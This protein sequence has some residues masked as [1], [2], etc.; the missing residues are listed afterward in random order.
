MAEKTNIAWCEATVNFWHGCKKVSEGCKYCYMYRDKERWKQDGSVVK[1]SKKSTITTTLNA[2]LLQDW[3]REKDG[4]KE[5]L[6][7]FT[8]SWSDFFI[9]QADDWRDEAWQIIRDYP[10]FIWIILTKRPERME[11]CL[12]KDWGQGWP[13]VWLCVSA[14]NQERANERIPILLKTPA[15]VRGVSCE[16]LLGPINLKDID[17]DDVFGFNVDALTGHQYHIGAGQDFGPSL[18]WVIVGGE[19]GN[20]TGK[21]RFRPCNIE[22]IRDIVKTT[23][24]EGVAT[25]VKQLGT[26]LAKFLG[27][28]KRHGDD[29]NEFPRDLRIQEF[30]NKT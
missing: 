3:Q 12:P 9:E 23:K 15:K 6:K 14:E 18:D 28:N 1:K 2:L 16:P 27:L 24:E 29:V 10:Q 22:W 7:I 13:N 30:P 20:N 17:G 26:D 5:P 8:C 19:S 11:Y 4:I 21:W 25:F